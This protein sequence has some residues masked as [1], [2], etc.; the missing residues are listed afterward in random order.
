MT[1]IPHYVCGVIPPH[2]LTAARAS[3]ALHRYNK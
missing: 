3:S 2:I 1:T